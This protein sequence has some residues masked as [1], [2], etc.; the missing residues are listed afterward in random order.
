[1]YVRTWPLHCTF[2]TPLLL[3]A[4]ETFGCHNEVVVTF[5]A[6]EFIATGFAGV[7]VAGGDSARGFDIA[8][9][10]FFGSTTISSPLE[11]F[12]SI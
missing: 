7:N 9:D 10:D 5:D 2:T 4:V 8:S 3:V 6:V 1:M 11:S 12:D